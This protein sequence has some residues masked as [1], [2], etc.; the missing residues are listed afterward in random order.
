MSDALAVRRIRVAAV[1]VGVESVALLGFGVAELAGLDPDHRSVALTTAVFFFLYAAGLALAARGLFRLRSWGRGPAVL[2]Q[3]IQLGVA[4]SFRGHE[5]TWVAL[6]LAVPA[7]GV[8]VVLFSPPTAE[9]L[10]GGGVSEEEDPVS[11]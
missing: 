11:S 5:T 8:L 1:A 7:V 10:Y 3:L 4:W 2:A 6:V 9:I